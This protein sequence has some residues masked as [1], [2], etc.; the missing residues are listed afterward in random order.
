M[1]FG[2]GALPGNCSAAVRIRWV[3]AFAG[4][5]PRKPKRLHQQN[6]RPL[7]QKYLDL[8]GQ[9]PSLATKSDPHRRTRVLNGAKPGLLPRGGLCGLHQGFFL[10]INW[11]NDRFKAPVGGLSAYCQASEDWRRKVPVILSDR[12]TCF[13]GDLPIRTAV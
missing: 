7:L 3:W 6:Q 8:A 4:V 12:T 5:G 13:G 11:H 10:E 9:H 2:P 1:A